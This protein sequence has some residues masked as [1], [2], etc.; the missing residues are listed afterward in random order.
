MNPLERTKAF[1]GG[2]SADRV[3]FHPILM[4]FA[5]RHAGVRYRDFCLSPAHKCNANIRTAIDF[6]SDWVNTMS[7]PWAEAEAFGTRLFYPEDDLPKVER[8]AIEDISDTERMS[9]LRPED[10]NRMRQRVEEIRIYNREAA[11][12]Y[13]ICGWVEG[14]LAAW[15]DM[16][17]INMAMTDMYEYPEKVH[18]AL[19]IITDSA[20]AFI[21]LQVKAGAHC[22][23]IGDSVCSLI[24]P[25]LYRE[26]CFEREKRLVDHIHSLGAYVKIHICGNISAI[27]SDVIMTGADIV[28]IDHRT[29]PVTDALGMLRPDQVFSGKS[30]PVSV[31]QEGD[32]ELI[33]RSCQEFY[34]EAGSRAILSAGC[35]VTPGTPDGNLSFFSSMAD[36][37]SDDKGKTT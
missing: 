7:D 20:I 19:D 31:L 13:F 15:C 9:V 8:Y 16:R 36:E 17:D 23:G 25:D 32:N 3:P 35:E 21:T 11:G 29:G 30:D 4:R 24:S 34:R 18:R 12:M 2:R 37:L 1:I 14:P 5:A 28:D 10:H 33:R 27:L 22:I 6:G 26:F